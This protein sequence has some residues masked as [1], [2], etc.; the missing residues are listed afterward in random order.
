VKGKS[1]SVCFALPDD[2]L[3]AGLGIF[4]VSVS[5][6]GKSPGP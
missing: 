3:P 2:K 5:V 1:N 6:F 4:R